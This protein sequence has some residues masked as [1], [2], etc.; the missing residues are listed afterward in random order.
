[1]L[2]ELVRLLDD[3]EKGNLDDE[4][5]KFVELEGKSILLYG[6]GN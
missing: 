3:F 1:M 2:S 5:G 4:K 6:A